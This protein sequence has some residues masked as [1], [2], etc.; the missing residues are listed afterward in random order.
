MLPYAFELVALRHL[1]HTAFGTLMAL[2]PAIGVVLGLLVLHQTLSAVQVLGITL[3]VLAG[4]GAQ[5]TGRRRPPARR[6]DG[7]AELDLIE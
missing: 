3:V 4:A 7:Q 1:S 5:R 6:P 2:E